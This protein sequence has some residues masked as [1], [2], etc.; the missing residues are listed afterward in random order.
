MLEHVGPRLRPGSVVVFD[1]YLNHPGWE[2]GEHR[3]WTE[4]LETVVRQRSDWRDF[5]RACREVI[6]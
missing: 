6:E 5:Y 1:E 4:Y 2:D 3:A